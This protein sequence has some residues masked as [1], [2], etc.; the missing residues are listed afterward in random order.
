[1]DSA[2]LDAEV[3]GLLDQLGTARES[4]AVGRA[5]EISGDTRV[6]LNLRAEAAALAATVIVNQDPQRACTL[7]RRA[8]AWM[9][10]NRRYADALSAAGC[11]S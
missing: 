10:A 7:W 11:G 6:P 9:P 2:A 1:L 3:F 8:R 5:L 4:T